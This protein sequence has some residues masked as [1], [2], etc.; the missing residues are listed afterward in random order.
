[1]RGNGAVPKTSESHQEAGQSLKHTDS[2]PRPPWPTVLRRGGT[3]HQLRGEGGP[4]HTAWSVYLG[5]VSAILVEEIKHRMAL[6]HQF[7]ELSEVDITKDEMEV[8]PT[9]G[10]ATSPTAARRSAPSTS[11]SPTTC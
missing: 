10:C 11:R 1:V 2:A 6:Y 3:R 9:L 7:M 5:I 4:R 8:G